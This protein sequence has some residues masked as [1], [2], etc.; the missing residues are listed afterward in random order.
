MFFCKVRK[1][2]KRLS[3]KSK[4]KEKSLNKLFCREQ[5]GELQ[6]LAPILNNQMKEEKEIEDKTIYSIKIILNISFN[7][8]SAQA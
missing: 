5:K 3:N 4:V 7:S 6:I 2:F 8:L 1:K